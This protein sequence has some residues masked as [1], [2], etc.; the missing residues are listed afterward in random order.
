MKG[1]AH[2]T[3]PYRGYNGA[4]AG[5]RS[6]GGFVSSVVGA[7]VQ[8]T[9]NEGGVPVLVNGTLERIARDRSGP[10]GDR[11]GTAP[12]DRSGT[13]PVRPSASPIVR[14]ALPREACRIE[15]MKS[16]FFSRRHD[17]VRRVEPWTY[18][19]AR[20]LTTLA[21]IP[22]FPICVVAC[23]EPNGAYCNQQEETP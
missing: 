1:L 16:T 19:R 14:P 13:A 11:S 15:P 4:S 7:V 3:S 18:A 23:R 22:A 17:H 12:R 8:R 9:A 10:L 5:A 2:A 6:R 20:I 21:I